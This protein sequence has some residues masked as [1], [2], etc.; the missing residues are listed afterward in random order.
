MSKDTSLK[1]EGEGATSEP[2]ETAKPE[3]KSSKRDHHRRSRSRDRGRDRR[4]KK[5]SPERSRRDRDRHRRSS[6]SRERRS[7]TQADLHVGRREKTPALRRMKPLEP[8]P[9][10]RDRDYKT[11]KDK[12][13]KNHQKKHES[14]VGRSKSQ[15]LQPNLVLRPASHA[16]EDDPYPE[17]AEGEYLECEICG[18]RF[19]Y[20]SGQFG[21]S[22]HI[23]SSHP[24]SA[25]ASKRRTYFYNKGVRSTS[26][27]SRSDRDEVPIAPAVPPPPPPL[28]RRPRPPSVDPV[29]EGRDHRSSGSTGSMAPRS[30]KEQPS[31]RHELLQNLLNTANQILRGDGDEQGRP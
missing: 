15:A 20:K 29:G 6:R 14:E 13:E 1:K 30:S 28:Q 2:R 10:D 12:H 21:V 18:K 31:H 4:S 22:Q 27:G 24:N 3:K 11:P 5:E 26:R 7:S 19:G 25:E 16:R 17:A 9:E 23:W 8:E